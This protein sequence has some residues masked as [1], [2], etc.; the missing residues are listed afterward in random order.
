MDEEKTGV[1]LVDDDPAVRSLARIIL[2]HEGWQV[3]EAGSLQE[4]FEILRAG[5]FRPHITVVDLLLPDGLGTELAEH[6]RQA[7]A[8]S[9]IVYITGD[10]GWLRRLS[11]KAETVLA[12]PFTPVQLVV[13]V[14]AALAT[15]RPVVVIVESGRVYQRLI[16]S[17]LAQESVKIAAASS[18]DEG[19]QMAR[20][21][22]A[23]VLLT[24]EPQHDDA[25]I[26][27]LEFRRAMPGLAVVA[28]GTDAPRSTLV[29]Y[30]RRL[31]PPYSAQSVAD[32][33]RHVLKL[34]TK[35]EDGPSKHVETHRDGDGPKDA[36]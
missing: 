6:L 23:A 34:R 32:A 15:M 28:L 5:G 29:W 26:R 19:L 2:Q 14:R 35:T 7:R 25:L 8:K 27:L 17:A 9:R 13:V 3:K 20:Q 22:E 36:S 12:K 21:Q 11:A 10:P 18:L 30:D 4:A 24:P 31:T 1:L 16:D 33:I